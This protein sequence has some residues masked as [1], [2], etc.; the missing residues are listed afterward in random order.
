M[1]VKTADKIK[2]LNDRIT[3][4]SAHKANLLTMRDNMIGMYDVDI[5]RIH[6]RQAG[7]F[8]AA[9]A[10]H[11]DGCDKQIAHLQKKIADLTLEGSVR[12][13]LEKHR[14]GKATAKEQKLLASSYEEMIG[15][16]E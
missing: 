9:T 16:I 6:H 13:A 5:G 3:S 7:S 1:P 4:I 15:A 8:K 12:A 10:E 11:L 2:A 14:Q